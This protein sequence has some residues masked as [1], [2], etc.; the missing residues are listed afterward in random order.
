MELSKRMKDLTGQTFGSLTAIRPLRLS[1]HG[2]V[3]W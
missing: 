3:I 1:E 2:T